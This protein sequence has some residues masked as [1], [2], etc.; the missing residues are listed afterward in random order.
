MVRV[1]RSCIPSA[2]S[3]APSR[4]G[5]SPSSL[6]LPYRLVDPRAMSMR[7][8][9]APERTQTASFVVRAWR[10][11]DGP[12]LYEAVAASREHLAHMPWAGFY[13]AEDA[14]HG[15]IRTSRARYL[16]HERFDL[17]I[18]TPDEQ[19]VLGATGFDLG[20]STMMP[21]QTTEVGMWIRASRAG[22]GLGS[23]VL[24]EMLRWG[25]EQWGW[26]R[27]EW[28]C[29]VNNLASRRCAEKAGMQHEGVLRGMYD[30]ATGGRRDTACYGMCHGDRARG[31]GSIAART[32]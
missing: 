16:L 24:E 6:D 15:Y 22:R 19:Q 20:G 31:L 3:C 18:W 4:R 32:P 21:A 13:N 14:A 10:E 27:I 8:R 1:G 9:Y 2:F 12:K 7:F 23:A 30:E 17:G 26:L 5:A 29:N 25:F 28:R 11:G